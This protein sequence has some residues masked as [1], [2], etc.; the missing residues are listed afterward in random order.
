MK[1]TIEILLITALSIILVVS[2]TGCSTGADN[3]PLVDNNPQAGGVGSPAD[4]NQGSQQ[5]GDPAGEGVKKDEP[6]DF[7]GVT[8]KIMTQGYP[9]EIEKY[10]DDNKMNETQQAFNINNRTYIVLTMGEQTSGGYAIELKDLALAD[11]VLKVS[12]KYV[13]PGKGDMAATVMTYPSLVI[14]TDDIYE[15]HYEIGYNIEK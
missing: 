5:T 11:G 10:L 7:N 12:A 2:L 6:I 14:E 9:A 1:K 8:A 15:G 4:N 3:K 13:K